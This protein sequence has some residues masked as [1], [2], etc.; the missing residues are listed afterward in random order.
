[1]AV[2]VGIV[3]HAFVN[4]DDNS[5]IYDSAGLKQGWTWEGVRWALTSGDIANWLPL[6]RLSWLAEVEL[7]G[8]RPA[9]LLAFNVLWHGLATALLYLALVR[10]SG[11]AGRSALVAA[12]FAVHPL[13]AESVAWAAE[14]RDLVCGAFWMATLWAYAGWA[15]RPSPSR[16]AALCLAL[17]LAL[18]AK[19]MA[20]TLPCVLLLL[21]VWP[22]GRVPTDRIG[23]ALRTLGRLG[24]EKLP[25]L[26]LVAASSVVTVRVQQA[27][28]AVAGLDHFSL[29]VRLANAALAYV[30]YVA[31][32]FRPIDL[33]VFYPHPGSGVP[34]LGA[35]VAAS[36]LALVTA[37]ALLAVRR[38]PW[39]AVGWLW[40]V[41]TLVPVIGIVQVG[42][43]S[44]ADR[45]MYLPLVGLALVSVWGAAE[46]FDRLRIGVTL[47]AALAALVV[48]A[49]AGQTLLQLRHW[50]DSEALFEH[51]LAVTRDNWAA[52]LNLGALELERGAL[53]RAAAHYAETLRLQPAL[54]KA[55]LG[56]GEVLAR[57]GKAEAA[58]DAYRRAIALDPSLPNV[59]VRIA[60]L[61]AE[62]QPTDAIP[63]YLDALRQQPGSAD[64]HARLGDAYLKAKRFDDAVSAL[65]RA[66]ALDPELG[67]Q[68][69]APLG[70]A[71]LQL[72]RSE[73]AER[74]LAAAVRIEPERAELQSS[75]ADALSALGRSAEAAAA[76]RA[77]LRLRSPWPEV[78][79]NLAWLLATDP[80]SSVRAPAEA[81]AL[82]ERA[83]AGSGRRDPRILDTLAAA[84][85]AAGRPAEAADA[86][87]EAAALAR[88]ADGAGAPAATLAPTTR[89]EP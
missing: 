3:G 44:H 67:R 29:T 13:H 11:A 17:T 22:L 64:L 62:R 39:I 84:Y 89:S 61:R 81:V 42:S 31:T 26:A 15:R 57:Q 21:D 55:H 56:Y 49:L 76:Y 72:G 32:F 36:G 83:A 80:D 68:L 59:Q 16:Y 70:V 43:Q 37:L 12:I 71:L 46:I 65:Q 28:G 6:V 58:L 75:H 52:H 50:R 69:H 53:D 51:A 10:L 1:M 9:P 34:M 20:V 85:A 35:L 41:G 48:A 2:H 24:I 23:S 33:A 77:A 40:F 8:L 63:A 7:F 87:R 66:I 45:Y 30:A 4:Y 19:P 14:R 47:R 73:D 38:R 60:A 25:L 54:A 18:L 5:L 74:E 79:N 78:E 86:A 88:A 82:A 27:G